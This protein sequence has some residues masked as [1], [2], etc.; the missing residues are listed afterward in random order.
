MV[1]VKTLISVFPEEEPP[2]LDLAIDVPSGSIGFLR[3]G[4]L[5]GVEMDGS[6]EDAIVDGLDVHVPENATV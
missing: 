3:R 5:N 6:Q 4:V 1:I 2:Y